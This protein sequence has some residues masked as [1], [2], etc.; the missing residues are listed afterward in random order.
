MGSNEC[1]TCV[2]F[3]NRFSVIKDMSVLTIP[4][5]LVGNKS[6]L[7]VARVVSTEEGSELAK[8]LGAQYFET[9]AKINSNITNTF[10]SLINSLIDV[11]TNTS[12]DS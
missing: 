11:F 8:S 6:D 1:S 3:K 2:F 9:S 12:A 5:I 4:I 7:E 10:D